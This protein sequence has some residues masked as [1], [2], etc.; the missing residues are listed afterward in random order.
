MDDKAFTKELDQWVEQLNECKQLNENQV[1]TLCEKCGSAGLE[2]AAAAA[3][4]PARPRPVRSR[5]GL[6][7]RGPAGLPPR[8]PFRRRSQRVRDRSVGLPSPGPSASAL[9]RPTPAAGGPDPGRGGSGVDGQ[10]N[11]PPRVEPDVGQVACALLGSSCHSS[12]SRV[13]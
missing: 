6:A 9:T 1:R 13:G 3:F 12:T 10:G 2:W 7:H 11:A 4:L 8:R 5:P